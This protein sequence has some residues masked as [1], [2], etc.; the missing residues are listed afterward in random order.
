MLSAI[1][2]QTQ[3]FGIS[4]CRY[5]QN[6]AGF[7]ECGY[8]HIERAVLYIVDKT[9]RTARIEPLCS[10]GRLY[11]KQKPLQVVKPCRGELSKLPMGE[12]LAMPFASLDQMQCKDTIF[13]DTNKIYGG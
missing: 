10:G 3:P 12:N 11:I 7:C 13:Y 5:G 2:P 4:T 8:I 6:G 9:K 1:L